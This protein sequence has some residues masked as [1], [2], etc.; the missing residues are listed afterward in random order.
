MLNITPESNFLNNKE[1]IHGA[2]SNKF[3]YFDINNSILSQNRIDIWQYSLNSIRVDQQN[4]LSESELARAS[5]FHFAKHQH[6]FTVAHVTKRLILSRYLEN[7][8]PNQLEFSENKYGKPMLLNNPQLEFN[9]SHSGD[10]AL[11]AI[12]KKYPLGIDL[13]FFSNRSY[14]DIGKNMFSSAEINAISKVNSRLEA[15]TFF[16]IWSQKEAFIKACGL[17]LVYPTDKFSVPHI[18]A[19]KFPIID[20]KTDTE[21]HITSFMPKIACG[22]AICHRP[23]INEI[24]YKILED[25]SALT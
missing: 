16:N 6:R 8:N 5:R 2:I 25:I 4:I 18:Q 17:G 13:E 10:L 1:L 19:N 7:T 21:W 15:L 11:L 12:G 3:S 24:R 23:Q 14:L 20:L 22:G 9:L